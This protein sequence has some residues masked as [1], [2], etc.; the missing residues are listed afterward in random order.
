MLLVLSCAC[1]SGNCAG[2][3]VGWGRRSRWLLCFW[4]RNWCRDPG[5]HS[6]FAMRD[7]VR[8]FVSTPYFVVR[9]KDDFGKRAAYQDRHANLTGGLLN[10]RREDLGSTVAASESIMKHSSSSWS[11]EKKK[12]RITNV[13]F[14]SNCRDSI[15][16][17]S[18]ARRPLHHGPN[19]QFSC[20]VAKTLIV[21]FGGT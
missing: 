12:N 14:F 10:F 5:R 1:G 8:S 19:G 3:R 21:Y 4:R 16:S 15:Q 13:F 7:L 20:I 2:L 17:P 9:T 6:E 11:E 18:K